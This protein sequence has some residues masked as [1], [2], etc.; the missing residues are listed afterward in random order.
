MKK[1]I[2]RK[3][4]IIKFLMTN[5]FGMKKGIMGNIVTRKRNKACTFF[6]KVLKLQK[7]FLWLNKF[8]MFFYEV[9]FG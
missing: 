2:V 4:V 8:Q 7:Q 9:N 3:N 1:K 5:N 6:Y